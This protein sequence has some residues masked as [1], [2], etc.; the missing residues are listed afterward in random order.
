MDECCHFGEFSRLNDSP[1]PSSPHNRN[2]GLISNVPYPHKHGIPGTAYMCDEACKFHCDQSCPGNCCQP[3][4]L[5][6]RDARLQQSYP[7]NGPPPPIMAYEPAIQTIEPPG[8]CPYPCP[9]TCSPSCNVACCAAALGMPGVDVNPVAR[10][11]TRKVIHI[12][13]IIHPL[14]RKG[15]VPGSCPTYCGNH[16]TPVCARSGCC[17]K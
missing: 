8:M 9:G 5:A 13:H 14:E 3:E 15:L 6:E 16:C 7:Y 12:T 11:S 1:F 4:E 17:M 10:S 2:P